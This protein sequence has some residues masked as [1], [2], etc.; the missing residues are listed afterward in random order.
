MKH[1]TAI[2]CSTVVDNGTKVRHRNGGCS[3]LETFKLLGPD[4]SISSISTSERMRPSVTTGYSQMRACH[5]GGGA[6][7]RRFTAAAGGKRAVA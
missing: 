1:Q 3:F 2:Y 6:Q 5:G 4:P 7:C